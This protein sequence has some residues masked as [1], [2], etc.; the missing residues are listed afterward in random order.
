MERWIALASD[1]TTYDNVDVVAATRRKSGEPG[2]SVNA[3]ALLRKVQQDLGPMPS[4]D[5]PTAFAVWGAA[6]IN[7][8][9]AL[10]VSAELRGAMLESEGA[11]GN[12]VSLNE[13]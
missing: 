7:S 3:S 1:Q 4:P 11:R 6:L 13:V 8:L 5:N 10:G 2:L 12:F 9:P